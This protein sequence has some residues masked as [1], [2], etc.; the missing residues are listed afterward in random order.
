MPKPQI[1][2]PLGAFGYPGGVLTTNAQ[3]NI[4]GPYPGDIHVYR[5]AST[6]SV[7]PRG[8]AV[9]FST[10]GAFGTEVDMST[11]IGNRLFAGIAISSAGLNTARTTVSTAAGLGGIG[12]DLVQVQVN[13]TVYGALLTSCVVPGDIVYP[14]S[15]T[16]AGASTNGGYLT[17]TNALSTAA[18]FSGLAGVA[19][20]SGTTGTTGFLTTAGPRGIVKLRPALTVTSTL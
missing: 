4:T 1:D 19:L 16:V 15:S 8:A 12:S 3:P 17:S 13:G 20:T 14:G 9:C 11:I 10:L 18:G 2:N 5:N 6:V 7:I